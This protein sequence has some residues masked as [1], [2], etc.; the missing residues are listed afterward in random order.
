MYHAVRMQV[1]DAVEYLMHKMDCI[2]FRE[3]TAFDD[4]IKQLS[5]TRELLEVFRQGAGEAGRDPAGV[6]LGATVHLGERGANEWVDEV[7]RWRE[8]GATQVT[9]R[10]STSDYTELGQH[11]DAFARFREAVGES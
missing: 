9:A 11:L 5:S 10:T 6:G 2:L 1:L 4:T 3:L 7:E 8:L